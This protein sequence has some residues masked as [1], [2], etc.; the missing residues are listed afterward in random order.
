M[1][2]GDIRDQEIPVRLLRNML[3][4]DRIPNGLLFWGPSGVGKTTAAYALARALSCEAGEV[5][6][7]GECLSCRKIDHG[8][9]PDIHVTT[10]LK[11]SRNIDVKAI[12]AIVELASLRPF[13]AAWRVFIIHDAERMRPA[14]QHHLLKTLEEPPGRCVF[15]LLTEHPQAL[16]PTIRS[17]CQQIRFGSLSPETVKEVLMREREM[18]E[19]KAGAIASVAQGQITRAVDLADNDK[20][21]IVFEFVHRLNSGA[22]PLALSEEFGRYLSEEKKGV[23]QEVKA[24]ENR[25][26]RKEFS[27][28]DRERI[29]EEQQA[30][31]DA[32]NRRAILETL[33]LVESWYRDCLVLQATGESG[34]V[35]NRDE[36][37]ELDRLSGRDIE[38]RLSAIEK[39]RRYLERHLQEERVFRDLF[40]ALAP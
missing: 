9:H 1:S 31:V 13:E 34:M 11:K 36:L 10:P 29:D 18:P 25:D 4:Q 14:S 7:C 12:D 22:D 21:E 15:M 3:R 35:L 40:F 26:E 2:F 27:K 39:A 19:E 37:S 8:N 24:A 20:R 32:L 38:V 30:H 23:Q 5:D 6:D 33:H 16:L 28:E 17:R